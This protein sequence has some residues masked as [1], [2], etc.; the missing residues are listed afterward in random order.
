MTEQ[1][2]YM[3]AFIYQDG[4]RHICD[5]YG[6]AQRAYA[7][8]SMRRQNRLDPYWRWYLHKATVMTMEVVR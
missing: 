7:V 8:A 2:I 4:R 5:R 3:L 1:P 6:W